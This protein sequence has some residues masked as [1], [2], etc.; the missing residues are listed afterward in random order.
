MSGKVFNLFTSPI[1]DTMAIDQKIIENYNNFSAFLD[2][3]Q[4]V[5]STRVTPG[6]YE[7]LHATEGAGA[8]ASDI[9]TASLIATLH[10]NHI[11]GLSN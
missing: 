7:L 8:G 3:I 9:G 5:D 4:L 2:V 1:Y 6:R 10:V 11:H